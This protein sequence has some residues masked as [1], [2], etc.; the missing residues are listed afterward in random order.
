MAGRPTGYRGQGFSLRGEKGRYVLPPAFRKVFADNGDDRVLCIAK[1]EKY[2]CLIAFGLSR[3]DTFEDMLDKEEDSAIRRGVEYDRDLRSMQLW[4][5]SEIPFDTSGRFI[6][7][8]HLAE[9]GGLADGIYF[10]G[11]GQFLALW[12]PERLYAM[13]DGLE[14]AKATCRTMAADA[15][16]KARGKRK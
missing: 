4:G 5:F 12:D 10:Q 11:G 9:L 15:A 8:D 3:S 1:H 13:G 6:L 16:A 7:P 14:G 2:P